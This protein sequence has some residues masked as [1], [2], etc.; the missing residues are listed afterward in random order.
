MSELIEW[1][2]IWAVCL[3]LR[4]HHLFAAVVYGAMLALDAMRM[5]VMVNRLALP[6]LVLSIVVFVTLAVLELW[7]REVLLKRPPPKALLRML[8]IF[9]VPITVLYVGDVLFRLRH[10]EPISQLPSDQPS[11][12]A[13]V[14]VM[15]VPLLTVI[16]VLSLVIL[17]SYVRA[18][19]SASHG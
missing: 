16:L 5:T 13:A 2:G 11:L 17:G 6:L 12:G 1:V 9:R 3:W 8:M 15:S 4:R 18:V 19:R 7:R 10:W 14:G